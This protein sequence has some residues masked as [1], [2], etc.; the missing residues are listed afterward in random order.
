MRTRQERERRV[1]SE[2]FDFALRAYE[3][4]KE[5]LRMEASLWLSQRART[6]SA[7]LLRAAIDA[8]NARAELSR[9]RAWDS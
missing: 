9:V 4:A 5:R 3:S 6:P 2:R 7:G 8:E 1:G